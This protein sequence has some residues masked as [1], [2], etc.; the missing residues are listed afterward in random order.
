MFGLHLRI[1]LA[2]LF[3]DRFAIFC[4]AVVV[5]G[6]R[7]HCDKFARQHEALFQLLVYG[8]YTVD[9]G[10]GVVGESHL[11]LYQVLH[12]PAEVREE[13]DV[14]LKYAFAFLQPGNIDFALRV[15]M[16]HCG[17]LHN[18]LK[19]ELVPFAQ[20]FL[21]ANLGLASFLE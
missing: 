9:V 16:H 4:W 19:L 3:D 5:D 1:C 10:I 21:I 2:R 12:V 6:Y 11:H 18:R 15:R 13:S 14:V 7:C 20:C 17:E 8:K